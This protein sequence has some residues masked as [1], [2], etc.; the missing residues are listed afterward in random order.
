M[1]NFPLKPFASSEKGKVLK[2]CIPVQQYRRNNFGHLD[3]QQGMGIGTRDL[4]T[5]GIA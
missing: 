2:N 5:E 3:L 1:P 4:A